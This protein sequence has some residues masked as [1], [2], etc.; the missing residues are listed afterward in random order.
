MGRHCEDLDHTRCRLGELADCQAR[1]AS[2]VADH[3]HTHT[4]WECVD[5]EDCKDRCSTR[6]DVLLD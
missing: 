3:H 6:R 2:N 4:H 5:L 1:P